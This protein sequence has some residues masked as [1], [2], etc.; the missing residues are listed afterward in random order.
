MEKVILVDVNDNPIG[1]EEKLE[2]HKKGLLHRCFSIF[3]FNS[4]GKLLLQRR[5]K[6]KYHSGGLW[7]NTCCSHPSP[8]EN[9]LDA[10]HRRLQE[11]MGIDTELREVHTFVYK[12]KLDNDLTEYEYDHVFTGICDNEP[13]PNPDEISDWK[14]VDKKWLTEDIKNNPD[15]Y[16]YWLKDCYGDVVKIINSGP[17]V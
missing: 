2:A 7:T 3:I 6:E 9:T 8:G 11:E 5:A 4:V 10:A 13:I 15:V 16:T 14:W 17:M 12:A 1:E